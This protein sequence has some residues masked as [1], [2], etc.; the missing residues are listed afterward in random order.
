[1]PEVFIENRQVS[2]RC[3]KRNVSDSSGTTTGAF[4]NMVRRSL[5]K[6]RS[7]WLGLRL[8][9]LK[10]FMRF[11]KKLWIWLHPRNRKST[12]ITCRLTLYFFQDF[13]FNKLISSLAIVLLYFEITD[14]G[15]VR[16][17]IISCVQENCPARPSTHSESLV[18]GLWD[19]VTWIAELSR[20]TKCV[21]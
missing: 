14:D 6:S 16:Q 1:M 9:E 2:P 17:S 7:Y 8:V 19:F 18:R 11:V 10:Q 15:H 20:F 13:C 21:N 3:I 4:T 5:L 12:S